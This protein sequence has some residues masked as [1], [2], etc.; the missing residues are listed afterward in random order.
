M[1]LLP[2]AALIGVFIHSY[3]KTT[4]LTQKQRWV[5]IKPRK[6]L[7]PRFPEHNSATLYVTGRHKEPVRPKEPFFWFL[8]WTSSSNI[9]GRHLLHFVETTGRELGWSPCS[10]FSSWHP[11]GI[12]VGIFEC[13][14]WY[15]EVPKLREPQ[16]PRTQSNWKV[17][18]SCIHVC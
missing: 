14:G 2:L 10:S 9:G 16:R 13:P 4:L 12:E 3:P 11:L 1:S 18:I 17:L 15:H 8:S 7:G 6:Q 5:W